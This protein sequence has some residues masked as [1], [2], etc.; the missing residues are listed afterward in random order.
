MYNHSLAFFSSLQANEALN[1][2]GRAKTSPSKI[3]VVAGSSASQQRIPVHREPILILRDIDQ[4]R[5]YAHHILQERLQDIG[6]RHRDNVMKL[7][8]PYIKT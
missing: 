8:L 4:R 6:G 5:D 3:K 1:E 2:F 7:F